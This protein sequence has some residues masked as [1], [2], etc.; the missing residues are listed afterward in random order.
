ML[1]VS[2]ERDS[3]NDSLMMQLKQNVLF[4]HPRKIV[5]GV[6]DADAPVEL[7]ELVTDNLWVPGTLG[8]PGNLGVKLDHVTERIIRL[9]SVN[10]SK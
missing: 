9:K 3:I 6:V 1:A 4:M 10:W 2:E 8:A 7:H 5:F